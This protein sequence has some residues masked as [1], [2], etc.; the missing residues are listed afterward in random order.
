MLHLLSVQIPHVT[1]Q[2]FTLIDISED[3]FVSSQYRKQCHVWNAIS[4]CTETSARKNTAPH[5][6]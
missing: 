4:G 5:F 2:E 1:R 3:G 6:V